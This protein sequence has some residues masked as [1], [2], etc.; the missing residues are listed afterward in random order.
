MAV[1]LYQGADP[2]ISAAAG[3]AG[4]ALEPA[5]LGKTFQGMATGYMYGMRHVG[6]AAGQ[7]AKV[8]TQATT[9]MVE[10]IKS[11]KSDDEYGK[12]HTSAVFNDLKGLANTYFKRFKE[13][14]GEDRKK[15]REEFKDQWRRSTKGLKA[16][17]NGTFMNEMLVKEDQINQNLSIDKAIT[18]RLISAKGKP[19]NAPGR[20]FDGAYARLETNEDGEYV[21]RFYSKDGKPIHGFDSN[22]EIIHARKATRELS[23]D[24]KKGG[25]KGEPTYG[26]VTTSEIAPLTM[27]AKDIS[28]LLVTKEPEALANIQAQ[29]LAAMKLGSA[30]LDFREGDYI[31][32]V[33]EQVNT[34][35]RFND[36]THTPIG[37]EQST[38]AEH[39]SS[40]DNAWSKNMWA[41]IRNL[42]GVKDTDN[43]NVINENDFDESDIENMRILREQM[44]NYENLEARDLFTEWLVAAG[45]KSYDE[46]R[47]IYDAKIA[48]GKKATGGKGETVSD[49]LIK[50]AQLDGS[51]VYVR[52]STLKNNASVFKNIEDGNYNANS[53]TG[54][55]QETYSFKDNQ[56]YVKRQDDNGEI[57]QQRIPRKTILNAL[58]LT[59]RPEIMSGIGGSLEDQEFG[60][61]SNGTDIGFQSQTGAGSNNMGTRSSYTKNKDGNWVK[62]GKRVLYKN[63][64]GEWMGISVKGMPEAAA[65]KKIAE[66]LESTIIDPLSPPE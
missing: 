55:N 18:Q 11:I 53:F 33:K 47:S 8:A 59:S 38:Y 24:D 13:K 35:N 28:N 51:Q 39:L 50:T 56:W 37:N 16:M 36:L 26:M 25:I 44:L 46:R 42:D 64:N 27:T 21:Q 32:V 31:R 5:D 9:A 20:S 65:S 48:A 17:M 12:E 58:D 52:H 49:E 43:N 62:G 66:F 6:A 14:K 30:G 7:V 22:G 1:N 23:V 2:S 63:K 29:E 4:A 41:S 54:W 61:M 15:V 57:I 34:R 10:E 60:Y 19:L 40:P 3:R 45:K